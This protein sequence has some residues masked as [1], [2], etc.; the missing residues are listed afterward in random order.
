MY[1]KDIYRL[2]KILFDDFFVTFW[3][4]LAITI[5]CMVIL[6][7]CTTSQPLETSPE[8]AD[9]SIWISSS[10]DSESNDNDDS[11]SKLFF[12]TMNTIVYMNQIL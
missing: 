4:N 3:F 10:S 8:K 7:H 11:M 1:S 5:L 9:N 6:V 12:Y 2:S